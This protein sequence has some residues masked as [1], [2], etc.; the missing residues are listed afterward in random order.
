MKK[1]VLYVAWFAAFIASVMLGSLEPG[2]TGMKAVMIAVAVCF[3]VP[4]AFLLY[5]GLRRG[6]RKQI[7]RLRLVSMISLGGTFVLMVANFLSVTMGELAGQLLYALLIIV[8]APMVCGQY[9]V[10]SLFLWAC[11]LMTTI[12]YCPKK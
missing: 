3:F 11:I 5:D 8:S 1:S 6:D 12:L 4:P 7:L 2:S 9:W 10:V